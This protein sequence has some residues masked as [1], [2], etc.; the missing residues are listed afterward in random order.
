MH[1]SGYATGAG[2]KIYFEAQGVGSPMVLVHGWGADLQSNWV[3]TG[4]I[5]HLAP[6]RRLVALDVRGHGHSNKPRALAPYSYAEMA[7]DVLAVMDYLD[8]PQA[9]FLGYSMGAFMGAHLLGHNPSRL[10]KVILGG[11]GDE[12][13]VTAAQGDV[14]AAALRSSDNATIA[15]SMGKAVRRFVDA[16]PRNDRTALAYSAQRMWPEGYPL[17]IAGPKLA[18][19]G[20]PVLIVNGEH[21]HPYVD[22]AHRFADALANGEHVEISGT[23]HMTSVSDPRFKQL[24]LDFLIDSRSTEATT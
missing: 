10:H 3:D 4:W 12:T 16:N 23:D 1:S 22:S 7:N 15:D 5:E 6:H 8:I 13:P 17:R 9:D 24:V 18:T 11:I 2:G 21:D 19:A 20:C 14:I